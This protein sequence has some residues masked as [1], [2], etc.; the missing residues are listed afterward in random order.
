MPLQ[1]SPQ[2]PQKPELRQESN[3]N[4]DIYANRRY[5]CAEKIPLEMKKKFI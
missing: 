5:T 3:S 2:L 1:V 4:S